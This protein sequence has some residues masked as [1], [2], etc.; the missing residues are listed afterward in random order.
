LFKE[1]NSVS[2]PKPHAVFCV[3]RGPI[4]KWESQ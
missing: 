2:R 4:E 1:L 3:K